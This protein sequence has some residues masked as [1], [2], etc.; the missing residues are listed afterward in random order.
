MFPRFPRIICMFVILFHLPL[1][2]LLGMIRMLLAIF[3]FRAWGG[4]GAWD[5]SIGYIYGDEVCRA[6]SRGGCGVGSR[7]GY[8]FFGDG[9]AGVRDVDFDEAAIVGGLGGVGDMLRAGGAYTLEFSELALLQKRVRI[10]VLEVLNRHKV[11]KP[12]TLQ[13]QRIR[14]TDLS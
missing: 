1:P 2:L 10:E 9:F 3:Q 11:S 14:T 4:P 5:A 12:S 7:W 13:C 6:G 8:V